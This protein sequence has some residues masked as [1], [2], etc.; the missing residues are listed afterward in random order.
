MQVH[1]EQEE[2]GEPGPVLRADGIMSADD[3]RT[4]E[5]PKSYSASVISVSKKNPQRGTGS[6]NTVKRELQP[7]V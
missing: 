6:I 2:E 4:A 3:R 1:W 7:W 5:L